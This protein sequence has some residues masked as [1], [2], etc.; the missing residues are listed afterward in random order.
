M[1]ISAEKTQLMTN[2]TNDMSTDIII[3]NKKL[4]T[5]CRFKHL[6]A[7]VSDNGSTPEV[8]SGMAQTIDAVTKL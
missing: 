5:I 1:Q 3:D 6:G 7:I 4:E 2:S 8:L